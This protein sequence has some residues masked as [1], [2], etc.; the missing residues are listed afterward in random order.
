LNV[1]ETQALLQEVPSAYNTHI[2]DILLTAL[3]RAWSQSGRGALFTNLEG[4][5]REP[6]I[7]DLDLSRTVGWFTSIFPV[8]L[9]L[10]KSDGEW[11][12]GEA[13]KSVKEQLRQIPKRGIGY[14]VL[15]YLSR[16]AGLANDQEPSMVFNY[17]GQFD[18]VLAGSTL[19]GFASESTGPWH[20]P[21]QQRRYPLEINGIVMDGCLEF[22]WTYAPEIYSPAEMGGLSR[23]FLLA[24]RALI[25]HC[26]SP[27]ARGRTPSDFPL[28]RLDQTDVDR[29]VSRYRDIED[30]YPL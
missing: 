8:R 5:G 23:E 12:P 28:A 10:P 7:R 13:L 21:S 17:M 24:L 20:S 27:S 9:E 19:F 15:R 18:Q 16:A 6:L 26:Q 2:N 11:L 22:R 3:A 14:G 30:V 25:T 29:L 4:H 1:V